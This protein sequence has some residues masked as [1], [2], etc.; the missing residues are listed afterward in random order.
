MGLLKGTTL[1]WTS[2]VR[3]SQ[4]ALCESNSL[5]AAEM[6]K[7]FDHPVQ[8]KDAAKRLLSLRQGPRSVAEFSVQFRIVAAES[9]WDMKALQ[10]VFLKGLSE[11]IKDELAARYDPADLDAFI[12]L[13]I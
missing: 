13:A 9:G 1:D 7:V 2:V 11:Q 4:P 8:G 5:F 12:S 3:E 10:G 6:K